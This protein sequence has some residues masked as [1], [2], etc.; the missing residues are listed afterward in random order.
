LHGFHF[1]RSHSRNSPH[2]FSR[3]SSVQN[4][5]AQ[6]N[7]VDQIFLSFC[8]LAIDGFCRRLFNFLHHP[9]DSFIQESLLSRVAELNGVCN[10]DDAA[11]KISSMMMRS[12]MIRQFHFCF[13]LALLFSWFY[14]SYGQEIG[15]EICFCAPN[16]YEFTLD[17]SLFCPPVNITIGD[18]VAATTCMVSPFGD[19]TVADLI[20]VSVQSIDI[21]ELNQNLQ[22]MMQENIAGEFSD[23][24]SFQYTSYAALPGEIVNP[25]DL[26]RAI[27]VNIIGTNANGEPIINVYLITF[28]NSC[29]SYPVLFEGQSAGWTR[30][31]STLS[32]YL[33]YVQSHS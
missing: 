30:F 12:T 4:R 2:L 32:T 21:L 9:I 26:P 31:V 25:E 22:V 20:P 17:F 27:Q 14:P 24:D 23:G 19:P 11:M 33:K 8:R 13:A 6:V 29:G 15:T 1:A 16:T 5:S 10:G 3:F 18:A 7:F 28:T